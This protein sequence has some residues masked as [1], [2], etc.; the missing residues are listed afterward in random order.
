M[1][2]VSLFFF[3]PCL[4]VRLELFLSWSVCL[5]ALSDVIFLSYP[6]ALLMCGE[7]WREGNILYS[8]D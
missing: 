4:F 7:V 1:L 6:G 8:Y 5:A 2:L 3:L